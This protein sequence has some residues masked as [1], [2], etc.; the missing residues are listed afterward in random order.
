M[1]NDNFKNADFIEKAVLKKDAPFI[2]KTVGP[3]FGNKGG[4]IEVVTHE[5]SITDIVHISK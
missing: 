5:N 4:G 2:T 3:L 1:R